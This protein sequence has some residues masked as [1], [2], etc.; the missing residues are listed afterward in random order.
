[1]ALGH[2]CTKFHYNR[3]ANEQGVKFLI[4]MILFNEEIIKELNGYF[5]KGDEYVE[6][7]R[8]SSYGF[9]IDFI[10]INITCEE[11]VF[12]S[13]RGRQYEWDDAPNGAP[14]GLL[15]RQI[16]KEAKLVSP[17]RLR[18]LLNEDDY[19]EFET[20]EGGYESVIIKFP[21]SDET[22]NWEIF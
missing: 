6:S 10:N 17:S 13:I 20:V 22:L 19:I 5:S 15:G 14:W 7:I 3:C 9:H 16:A 8:L 12:A 1:M 18:V 4:R 21:E 11:R 2:Y